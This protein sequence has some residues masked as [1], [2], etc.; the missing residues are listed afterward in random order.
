MIQSAPPATNGAVAYSDMVDVCINLESDFPAVTRPLV[1]L[2]DALRA[3][4]EPRRTHDTFHIDA[5]QPNAHAH[6]P[7]PRGPTDC[8]HLIQHEF[9]KALERMGS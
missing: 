1:R 4:A 5:G 6:L 2:H 3:A 9:A 8:V 7:R